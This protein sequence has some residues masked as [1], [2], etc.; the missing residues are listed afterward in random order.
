MDRVL[1]AALLLAGCDEVGLDTLGKELVGPVLEV[2]PAGDIAFGGAAFGGAGTT[3]TLTLL[4]VGDEDLH[5]LDVAYDEDTPDAFGISDDLPLPL[6][7]P[8]GR[9]FPIE[10]YFAPE[11]VG[12]YN[13]WIVVTVVSEDGSRE[14]T[15]RVL[16]QG[17]DPEYAEGDCS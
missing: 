16:G 17:C 7:L 1:T 2:E 8:P 6:L 10:L 12:S 5:I 11:A 13:G 14:L 9:E 3:A 4:S 15:R